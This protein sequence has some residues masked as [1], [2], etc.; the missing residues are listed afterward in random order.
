M[1][2]SYINGGF[3][4]NVSAQLQAQLNISWQVAKNLASL[5][6]LEDNSVLEIV[7]IQANVIN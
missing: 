5:L 4:N 7:R 3:N 2:L 1:F 6:Y